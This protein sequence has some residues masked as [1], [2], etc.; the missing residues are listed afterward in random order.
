MSELSYE[1][2][3][4]TLKGKMPEECIGYFKRFSLCKYDHDQEIISTKGKNF[5]NKY[6]YSPDSHI[7]GC[8]NEYSKFNKC[9]RDFNLQYMDLKNY[10]ANINGEPAPYEK[11]ELKYN[12][13][14]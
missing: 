8:T 13:N 4:N 5:Y 11:S 7:D 6:I 2:I 10:V 12:K 14:I 1:S 9:V 3:E